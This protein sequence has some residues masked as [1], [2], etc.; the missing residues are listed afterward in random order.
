MGQ[1]QVGVTGQEGLGCKGLSREKEAEPAGGVALS[2]VLKG[3]AAP[4]S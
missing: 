2:T 4:L 1:S 3:P